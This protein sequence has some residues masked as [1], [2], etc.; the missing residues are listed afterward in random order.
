MYQ[1]VFFCLVKLHPTMLRYVGLNCLDRL[2]G[3]NAADKLY[4][5]GHVRTGQAK[6]RERKLNFKRFCRFLV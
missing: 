1:N 6:S 5:S 2:A 4:G 3:L